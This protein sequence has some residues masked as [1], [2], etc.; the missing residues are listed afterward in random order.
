MGVL[1]GSE[2]PAGASIAQA[3]LGTLAPGGNTA[4]GGAND[5]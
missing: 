4:V 2:Q 5:L 1:V 3:H